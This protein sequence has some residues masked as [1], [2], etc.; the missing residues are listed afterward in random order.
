MEN[1]Y[2]IMC[3][4]LVPFAI[5]GF[6][7]IIKD[8]KDLKNFNYE[9]DESETDESEKDTVEPDDYE[10]LNA[11]PTYVPESNLRKRIRKE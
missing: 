9:T 7:H 3:I 4:G 5:Y 8:L 2:K 10:K 11:D 1:Y 6:Y